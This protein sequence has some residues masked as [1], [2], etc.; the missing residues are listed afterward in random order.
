ML[1][2]LSLLLVIAGHGQVAFAIDGSDSEPPKVENVSLINLGSTSSGARVLIEVSTSDD[3]NKVSLQG[4]VDIQT[5]YPDEFKNISPL[6]RSANQHTFGSSGFQAL[7]FYEDKTSFLQAERVKQKFYL[8]TKYPFFKNNLPTGCPDLRN[9]MYL[10]SN[11][12]L[13]LRDET[14]RISNLN[15]AINFIP[16]N[17]PVED[18][19]YNAF[20][21]YGRNSFLPQ[22]E[23]LLKIIPGNKALVMFAGDTLST[24]IDIKLVQN[25][26]IKI[27]QTKKILNEPTLQSL[28]NIPVCNTVESKILNDFSTNMLDQ[29]K[30]AYINYLKNSQTTITCQKG[31]LT[32]K[33]TG[34]NPKCPSGFKQK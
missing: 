19:Q 32:K 29:V 7:G 27:E 11:L 18:Q 34:R 25:A 5:S 10:K 1:F 28:K 12:V 17:M 20:F 24:E 9:S 4:S 30:S 13:T 26:R 23:E 21:C 22:T 14:G 31:K 6:C 2:A 15:Q 33:V 16:L 3:K 8:L